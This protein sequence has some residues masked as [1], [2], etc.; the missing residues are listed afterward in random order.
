MERSRLPDRVQSGMEAASGIDLSDVRVHPGSDRAQELNALAFTEGSD[1]HVAPGQWSPGSVPGER[2]LAHELAHVVQQ[3][4]GLVAPTTSVA[5]S[6]VNDSPMLEAHAD[7]LGYRALSSGQAAPKAARTRSPSSRVVQRYES[8]EHA[9]FGAG[10]KDPATSKEREV[11][12]NKVTMTYGEMIAMADLFKD[13]DAMQHASESKLRE[14]VRLIRQ[15]RAFYESGVGAKVT[16][17]EWDKA[18][19]GDYLKLAA[20]NA[21]HFMGKGGH[22]EAWKASHRKALR[23]AAA[24][25][26]DEAIKVNAFG[27][28]FLTDAFS[29]GHLIERKDITDTAKARMSTA[30]NL[31]RDIAAGIL[32]D[33]A[34]ADLMSYEVGAWALWG[35]WKPMS[36]TSL[37]EAFDF[38]IAHKEGAF[39]SLFVKLV[40]D[41]L[42]KGIAHGAGL[43]VQNMR[44]DFWTL[45][46]DTTL[47][48]S[49][50]TRD[51]AREAVA[52]SAGNLA[53]AAGKSL[54]TKDLD[55]YEYRVW[56]LVP[57]P[58]PAGTKQVDKA[59][60]LGDPANARTL[61]AL[62]ILALSQLD[63]LI[64][65]M[66]DNH[67]FR[68]LPSAPPRKPIVHAPP[69]P[70]PVVPVT[71]KPAPAPVFP[72]SGP[73]STT[74][75]LVRIRTAPSL[76]ATT[77]GILADTGTAVTVITQ[78]RGDPVDGIDAW[79][80]IDYLGRPAYV[81]ARF[82]MLDADRAP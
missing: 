7:R 45:S 73:A 61:P 82:V 6:A 39:Y 17:E 13:A 26:M 70:P 55:V 62:V 42:N 24:G 34:A 30:P 11:V 80:Q 1:I 10:V 63:N 36:V 41:D 69:A 29:A 28:H 44:G 77:L 31:T 59:K 15:D 46:G 32:A 71:P 78:V 47:A 22:R 68:R 51:I 43:S 9:Q 8:G 60:E 3:R 2:L 5:G 56:N 16:D 27:D 66:V 52:L 48:L 65:Q 12:I 72:R 50:R 76:S 67:V 33:P 4:S 14:L 75:T 58:T 18:T 64:D 25:K 74:G 23:L 19:G 54:S 37:K 49:G 21:T 81:S 53:D 40:H 38:V 35:S 57:F 79:N 20:D